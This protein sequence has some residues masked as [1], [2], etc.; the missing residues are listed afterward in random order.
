[1]VDDADDGRGEGTGGDGDVH[2]GAEAVRH[3]LAP[4]VGG[5]QQQAAHL[6]LALARLDAAGEDGIAQGE[7][8]PVVGQVELAA[9]DAAIDACVEHA[10]DDGERSLGAGIHGAQLL[11]HGGGAVG[12]A[13]HQREHAILDLE[14]AQPP[15]HAVGGQFD[16]H[17]GI[18]AAAQI[19]QGHG[20]L[21]ARQQGLEVVD[22]H[23]RLAGGGAAAPGD[24]AQ[25]A[26]ALGLEVHEIHRQVIALVDRLGVHHRLDGAQ[27]PAVPQGA[28][29]FD[30]DM[31]LLEPV[32]HHHP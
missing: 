19:G 11:V 30:L 13:I 2:A 6:D 20:A 3:R 10:L 15:A 26:A 29:L 14:I 22:P 24:A 1:M 4:G 31:Q 23:P 27:G 18:D 28:G 17:L 25:R 9:V 8:D 5:T 12:G 16:L 7:V 21:D 32:A